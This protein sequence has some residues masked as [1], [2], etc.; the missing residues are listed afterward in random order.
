MTPKIIVFDAY[1]TLLNV[2]ALDGL[3]EHHFGDAGTEISAIWRSKQLQYTWL[4]TLME[5]Y[6]PFSSVTMEALDFACNSLKLKLTEP[7]KEELLHSYL[8]L[9]A[10]PEVRPVLMQLQEQAQLAVLSNADHAMLEGAINHNKLTNVF[11]EVLSADAIGHFKPR[12][13]VY[14]LACDA[15]KCLPTEIL[16]VSSNTWDVVGAKAY[17]FQVAWLNRFNNTPDH[18]GYREDLIIKELSELVVSS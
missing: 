1:G 15:F 6:K 2:N 14:Q 3:L 12:K 16:F 13:E 5:R 9:E 17:G 18:L 11:A 10:F 4:R 7:I 8:Q